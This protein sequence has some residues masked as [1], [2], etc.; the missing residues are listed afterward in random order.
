MGTLQTKG[1]RTR[2]AILQAGLE[3]AS[4]E[5]L[6]AITIGRLADR[7]GLSKSGLFAHFQS[8]EQLQVEVLGHGREAFIQSVVVPAL[9]APRGEPRLRQLMHNW[10]GWNWSEES[11]G[12]CVF[13][14]AAAEYD[15]REG[16][17][18][19][20]LVQTQRDL[21]EFLIGGAQLC[22]DE[23][24]LRKDTDPKQFAF[25]L[26]ALVMAHHFHIRLLEDPTAPERTQAGFERLM[27]ASK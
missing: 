16:P 26:F 11:R 23:G 10:L 21:L 18:R 17:V 8:K 24:H 15:D 12:G 25:E 6:E 3:V 14:Q 20:V 2:A 9:Q 4:A 27:K 7:V 5:G 13:L 22:V 1:D 19:D